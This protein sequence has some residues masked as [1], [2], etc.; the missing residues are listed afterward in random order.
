MGS[1]LSNNNLSRYSMV[2]S[3]NFSVPR[4]AV[5]D[6]HGVGASTFGDTTSCTSYMGPMGAKTFLGVS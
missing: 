2:K 3:V 1:S 6:L 5:I 4:H